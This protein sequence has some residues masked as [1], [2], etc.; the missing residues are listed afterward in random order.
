MNSTRH[1]HNGS[2]TASISPLPHALHVGLIP[3]SILGILSFGA[4]SLLFLLLSYRML[5]WNRKSQH[6]NQFVVLIWNLLL[7]DIQQ[8]LAFLLNAQWLVND[9]IE[10]GT[11]TC[12]A[13]GWFVSTGDLS[14]G[15][16]SFAIGVHTLAAVIFGYR[17]S[18]TKFTLVVIMIWAFVYFTAVAGVA[19][20][21]D[22]YVRA[23][24]WCWVCF[25]FLNWDRCH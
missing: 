17:L 7:A 5:Q 1:H 12:F 8:S 14:S 22:L 13:Q 10:V 6:I 11:S 23:V 20:H 24:A 25:E 16:W 21:P 4:A 2:F 19:M 3:V 9:G 15:M 18:N